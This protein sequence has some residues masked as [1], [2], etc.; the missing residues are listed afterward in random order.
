MKQFHSNFPDRFFDV[1]IAGGA[2]SDLCGRTYAAGLKPVV[3]IYSS[4]SFRGPGHHD[5]LSEHAYE[6]FAVDRAGLVGSDGERP[7]R[8]PTFSG[9]V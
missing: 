7:I 3:A 8:V 6:I 2:C 1:G 5:V 9:F 4:T